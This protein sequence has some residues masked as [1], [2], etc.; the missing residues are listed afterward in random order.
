MAMPE[1]TGVLRVAGPDGTAGRG[2]VRRGAVHRRAVDLHRD[3][4]VGLLVVGG[5]HLPH[6]AVQPELGAGEGQRGAPL[7]GAGLRRQP[8]DRGTRV[9]ERLRDGGVRLVRPGR[10]DALVLVVDPG[11]RPQRLLQPVRPVQRR[12]A[13]QAVHVEHLARDV[14]VPLAGDLLGDQLV[15]EQRGQIGRADRLQRAR[16]QRRRGRAGQVG[17]E[18]VPLRG[19]LRLVEQDL[20]LQLGHGI[21]LG[22]APRQCG[23]A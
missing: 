13:P 12:R 1:G 19:H 14:D 16:M 6:L 7:P 9:V 18:V 2:E 11:R 10:R 17:H 8:A 4:P 20:V 21:P 3:P 15:G 23:A 22:V 5:A